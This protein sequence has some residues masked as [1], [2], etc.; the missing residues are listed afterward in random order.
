MTLS[1]MLKTTVMNRQ[2]LHDCL[3]LALEGKMTFPETVARMN[4][5]GVERYLADLVTLEKTH[6]APD[7]QTIVEKIAL[8]RPP[9]IADDFSVE[10]VQS[11]IREI[12]QRRIKYDAFLRLIMQAGVVAY[13]VH[14]GGH[15]AIYMG[16]KGEMHVEAFPAPA[17]PSSR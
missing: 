6:Y 7:G 14:L 17:T 15:R 8:D 2:T 13:T 10:G 5:E 16:R 1:I 4:Q 12:Q 11:A 3:T 9:A